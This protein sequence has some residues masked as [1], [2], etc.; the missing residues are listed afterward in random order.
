MKSSLFILPILILPW[1]A[2]CIGMPGQLSSSKSV[3]DGSREI[4]IEPAWVSQGWSPMSFKLGLYRN[5]NMESNRAMLVALGTENIS[6]GRS[7]KFN[8]DGEVIALESI[9]RVSEISSQG[10]NVF[11]SKRYEIDLTLPKRLVTGSNVTVRIEYFRSHEDG[12]F[13]KDDPF[14]ARPAFRKFINAVEHPEIL[15]VEKSPSPKVGGH[16]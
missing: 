4:R 10:P 3:F 5:S 14:S 11:Y 16:R 7:L 9:D 8:I 6:D 13:S 15:A 2:G 12:T 1:L